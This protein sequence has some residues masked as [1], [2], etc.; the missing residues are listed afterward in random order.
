MRHGDRLTCDHYVHSQ[1]PKI[2]R[3]SWAGI[4]IRANIRG[5]R[6]R[7]AEQI[8]AATREDLARASADYIDIGICDFLWILHV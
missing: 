6:T 3:M 2:N 1:R 4:V 8:C 5:I 7:A